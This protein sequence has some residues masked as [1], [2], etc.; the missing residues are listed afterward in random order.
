MSPTAAALNTATAEKA[1]AAS[2]KRPEKY[3]AKFHLSITTAMDQSLQR[4][5]SAN[6]L[7]TGAQIGRLALHLY[8]LANDPLYK[9]AMGN[10]YGQ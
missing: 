9:R 6:S 2:K 5:S 8:L 10:G 7:A 3:P 1:P 4:L